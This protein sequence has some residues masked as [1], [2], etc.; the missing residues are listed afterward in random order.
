MDAPGTIP[1]LIGAP[2][3]DRNGSLVA[4]VEDLLVDERSHRPVWLLVR[5][6]AAA[7]PFTF[8][9]ADRVASRIGCV[10]VHFD[11][12]HIRAAPVRLAAPDDIAREHAVRLCR[13]YGLAAGAA[14][15]ATATRLHGRRTGPVA[16]AA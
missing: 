15:V 7:A 5:L 8:V 1:S 6:H 12:D 9:P 2:L 4:T 13:H 11:E 16:R 10:A 3:A 14:W